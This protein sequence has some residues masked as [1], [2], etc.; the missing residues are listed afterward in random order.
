[1]QEVPR[2][3]KEIKK[4]ALEVVFHKELEELDDHSKELLDK[5]MN[6]VEKKYVSVPMKMAK[7]ILLENEPTK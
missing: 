7:E 5:V 2:K 4:A 1:M 6:Y 3:V